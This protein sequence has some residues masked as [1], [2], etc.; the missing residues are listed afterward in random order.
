[1]D[2]GYKTLIQ[3]KREHEASRKSKYKIESKNRLKKIAGKKIQTTMIGALHTIETKLGFLWQSDESE[4]AQKL[5]QIYEEIRQEILDR[6]NLQIR[7][8][9]TE[10]DQYDIEWLR[11]NLTLPVYRRTV[12]H[13]QE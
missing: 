6:G 8:L 5:K 12:D 4:S 11:Y 9:N 2:N 1:M 10:L 13:D 7:N 3:L